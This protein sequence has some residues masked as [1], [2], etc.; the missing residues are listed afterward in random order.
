M[1]GVAQQVLEPCPLPFR[2][3]DGHRL[4][5]QGIILD[6]YHVAGKVI[7]F[8]PNTEIGGPV[9]FGNVGWC[10][11]SQKSMPYRSHSRRCTTVAQLDWGFARTSYR[12][13]VIA[14]PHPAPIVDCYG[15]D[16]GRRCCRG[17]PS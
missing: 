10:T 17:E 14:P 13:R 8:Q 15:C 2:E 3:I 9:V 11:P 12:A 5:N 16:G 1:D 7:V 6:S 4:D